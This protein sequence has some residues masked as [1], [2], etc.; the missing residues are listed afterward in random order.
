[1]KIQVLGGYKKIS[2]YGPPGTN[3]CKTLPED[4]RFT[5]K[6][7]HWHKT[8]EYVSKT[9]SNFQWPQNFPALL[10]YDKLQIYMYQYC[11]WGWQ[12]PKLPLQ[13][14]YRGVNTR[15][16][17]RIHPYFTDKDVWS[18]LKWGLKRIRNLCLGWSSIKRNRFY[19]MYVSWT[20]YWTIK[21]QGK[22]EVWVT[23]V[24][25]LPKNTFKSTQRPR[26]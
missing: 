15:T 19:Y 26:S 2:S 23:K 16:P 7:M 5:G 21:P 4:T 20:F 18:Y 13:I 11:L 9:A 17:G 24:S 10:A 25:P 3:P 1:M 6:V 12:V 22:G 14:G 8:F